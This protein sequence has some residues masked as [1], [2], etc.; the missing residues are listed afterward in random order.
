M[1]DVQKNASKRRNFACILRAIQ[2]IHL[3]GPCRLACIPIVLSEIEIQSLW[4]CIEAKSSNTSRLLTQ[5]NCS[6]ICPASSRNRPDCGPTYLIRNTIYTHS[7]SHGQP[8][9]TRPC[10]CRRCRPCM[11]YDGR[12]NKQMPDVMS[13]TQQFRRR[14]IGI[15]CMQAM[16]KHDNNIVHHHNS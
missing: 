14:K 13:S 16:S 9:W 7:A 4:R 3:I 15:F 1:W 8:W 6:W 12:I 2:F 11:H 10:P 5:R